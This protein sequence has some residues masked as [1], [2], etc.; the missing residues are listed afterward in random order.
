MMTDDTKELLRDY[1]RTRSEEAFRAMVR[2]HSPTV[3]GTALRK[4]GGNR[5]AAQDVTQEVFTLLARKAHQ[6]ESVVLG[7]WLYRQACR[8]AAN[9][10][11]TETRRRR[12]ESLAMENQ[13]TASSSEDFPTEELDD[14]LLA[15]PQKDRDALILRFFENKEFR[16]L[17][18]TLGLS[19]EAARK[20]VSRALERLAENL[21]R[22]G[23]PVGS[24]S[25]GTAMQGFGATPVPATV[26]S[27]V[28]ENAQRAGSA[29][30][31]ASL[32]IPIAAGVVATSLVASLMEPSSKKSSKPTTVSSQTVENRPRSAP[33]AAP[34]TTSLEQLIIEVQRV[35]SK[36]NNS[37]TALQLRLLFERI[38][39]GIVPDFIRLA[40]DRMSAAERAAVYPR[41]LEKSLAAAPKATMDFVLIEDVGKQADAYGGSNLLNNLFTKWV[42]TDRPASESWLI[43]NW[44][45]PVLREPAFQ[46]SLRTFLMTK[47]VEDRFV[48]NGVASVLELVHEIPALDD[49][50]VV[51]QGI[52]GM[53]PWHTGWAQ[54][55]KQKWLDF[56]QALKDF[57][58]ARLSGRLLRNFWKTLSA[59]RPQ[60]TIEMQAAMEPMDRFQVS[61]G[62]MAVRTKRDKQTP[63]LSGFTVQSTPIADSDRR[64]A[65]AVEAGLA[66]GLTK[67][68]VMAEIGRVM[69]DATN[70]TDFF[71]WFDAQ[72]DMS[73]M[74]DTLAEKTRDA[75]KKTGWTHGEEMIAVDWASRISDPEL[76]LKLCRGT[77]RM[78]LA[79]TRTIALAYLK[80]PTL[81]TDLAEAFQSILDET[82]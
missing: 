75:A 70:R 16:A 61:L 82:P 79:R 73:G 1:T 65:A 64:E 57:P 41:L 13:V 27:H 76:R 31:P 44:E 67:A 42:G 43:E 37:L 49:Q 36:P 7:G 18:T 21:K 69:V 53:N 74:D 52:A 78:S 55:N 25:L 23:V 72:E 12:R 66:A 8:R 81:P 24:V 5:A 10:V 39:P 80:D 4:L 26:I 15:L 59:E 19:E 20:R 28:S 33:A 58:D 45:N 35:K 51:L 3:Y 60:E 6:L 50:A 29:F 9:H 47:P 68:Q 38:D 2:A 34:Q 22:R 71:K 48:N 62:W 77:F 40:N 56:H 11:R 17:G 63:T 14:A 46:V 54:G 30:N 32:L